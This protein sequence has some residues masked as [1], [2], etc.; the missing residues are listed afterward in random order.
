MHFKCTD[1]MCAFVRWLSHLAFL[2][3]ALL[4]ISANSASA[5]SLSIGK[6]VV[7]QGGNSGQILVRDTVSAG[8]VTFTSGNPIPAP[9]DWLGILVFGSATGTQFNGSTFEFG[10]NGLELRGASP[11]LTN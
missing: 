2:V 11:T 8:E 7:V 3:F 10:K 9:G 5:A 6:G 1:V 4:L